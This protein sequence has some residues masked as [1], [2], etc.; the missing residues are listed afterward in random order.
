MRDVIRSNSFS[1]KGLL[2]NPES[3]PDYTIS[4]GETKLRVHRA[5]LNYFIPYFRAIF[6]GEYKKESS[7]ITFVEGHEAIEVVIRVIYGDIN[8]DDIEEESLPH[9]KHAKEFLWL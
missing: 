8:E 4:I 9:Y 2:N 3:L 7:E 6:N 1:L 5:I